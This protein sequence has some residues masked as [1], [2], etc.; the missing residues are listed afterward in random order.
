MPVLALGAV[1]LVAL[2]VALAVLLVLAAL[3]VFAQPIQYVLGHVPVIGGYLGSAFSDGLEA[4]MYAVVST[5]DKLAHGVGH[6]F[7]AL[8][9]GWWHLLYQNVATLTYLG[10]QLYG[11]SVRVGQL[12]VAATTYVDGRIAWLLAVVQSYY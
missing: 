11:L 10:Q 8:A 1:D 5:Y 2:T 9:V 7:W 6:F 12:S 4:A 3:W